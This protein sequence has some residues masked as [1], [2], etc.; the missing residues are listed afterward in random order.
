MSAP[1]KKYDTKAL[2]EKDRDHNIHPWT[3]FAS[4]KDEG[5]VVMSLADGA[6]GLD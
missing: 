2:W 6:Y 1:L 4:F 5:A 3:D